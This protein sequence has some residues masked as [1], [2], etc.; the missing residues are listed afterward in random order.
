LRAPTGARIFLL[1]FKSAASKAWFDD[2]E[3]RYL[4]TGS[5]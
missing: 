3:L 4:E 2:T 1:R 5:D